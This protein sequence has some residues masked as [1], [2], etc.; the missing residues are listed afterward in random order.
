[1]VF[2]IFPDFSIKI[3]SSINAMEGLG[4]MKGI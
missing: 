2:K 3:E 1:M 4:N